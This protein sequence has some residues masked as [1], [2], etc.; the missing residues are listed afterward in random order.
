MTPEK[1]FEHRWALTL[2]EAT[3]ERLR[4]EFTKARKGADFD[5]LEVFLSGEKHPAS[6]AEVA[7]KLGRSEGATRVAVHRLR[8]RYGELLRHAIAETLS[9]PRE[10]DDELHR[11]FAVLSE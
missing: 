5:A 9:D 11:L 1:I 2:L 7:R 8:S 6:Y 10:V 4:A 3:M